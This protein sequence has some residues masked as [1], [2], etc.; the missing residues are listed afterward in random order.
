MATGI[1]NSLTTHGSRGSRDAQAL[2]GCC[3]VAN[4]GALDEQLL[5]HVRRQAYVQLGQKPVIDGARAKAARP[6]PCRVVEMAEPE[7]PPGGLEIPAMRVD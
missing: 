3:R 2:L 4:A 1:Q 7:Q 6:L 5:Q